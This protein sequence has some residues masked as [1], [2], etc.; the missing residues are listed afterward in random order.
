MKKKPSRMDQLEKERLELFLNI[1]IATERI[2]EIE[3]EMEKIR[4]SNRPMA[5]FKL[6]KTRITKRVGIEGS[7]GG[8]CGDKFGRSKTT[9]SDSPNKNES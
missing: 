8:E 3:M 9:P 6:P 5:G 2:D 1:K 4:I 7:S